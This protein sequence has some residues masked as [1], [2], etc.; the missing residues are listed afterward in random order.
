MYVLR[1]STT[2]TAAQTEMFLDGISERITIASGRTLVFEI[3]VSARSSANTSAAYLIKGAID[4]NGGTTSFLNTP[5]VDVLGEDDGAWDAT[6]QADDTNDA[7]VLKIT[8][9]ASATI[10]WVATVRTTEV[11]H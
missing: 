9:T 3:Q 1:T 4:N 2:N 7:L 5:I 10:R 6:V 8:G 11:A